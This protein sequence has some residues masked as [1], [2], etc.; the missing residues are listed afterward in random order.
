MRRLTIDV[1]K[2]QMSGDRRFVGKMWEKRRLRDEG[3]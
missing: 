3:L 2:R 1:Y